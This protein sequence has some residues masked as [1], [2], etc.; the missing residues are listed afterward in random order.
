[1]AP[2]SCVTA[3]SS[4]RDRI[5][6]WRAFPK[7]ASQQHWI[8]VGAWLYR[9]CR[10]PHHLISPPAAPSNTNNALRARPTNK[11]RAK[12]AEFFDGP[13]AA[14]SKTEALKTR[15]LAALRQFAAHGTTTLEAKSGYGLASQSELAIL[16]LLSEL[17]QEQPIDIHSTFLGATLCLRSFA[18]AAKPMSISSPEN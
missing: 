12:A 14:A 4:R 11:S 7:R 8:W 10:L 1:M 13:R 9:L 3:P 16:R 17:H 18:A 2:Y 15:A 6:R 5:A